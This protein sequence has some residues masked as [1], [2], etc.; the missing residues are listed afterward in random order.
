MLAFLR[1]TIIILG[2][3][4]SLLP[5]VLICLLRPF[6]PNLVY[7]ASRPYFW[8]SRL[9]GLSVEYRGAELL[10]A[11]D[12]AVY[13]SN[14]QNTFDLFVCAGAVRPNTVTIGKRSLL[15]IPVFG[16]LYWITGNILID[17]GNRSK[18]ANTI[19]EAARKVRERNI[20]VWMFPEGTRSNKRGMLNFKTGAFRLA[21]KAHEP[22]VP[23]VVSCLVDKVRLNRWSNGKVIIQYLP[24][25]TVDK[26]SDIQ[27]VTKQV[28]ADML[29][30]YER[31]SAETDSGN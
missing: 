15:Y 20:S 22:I 5:T 24:P 14:H 18:A 21:L 9:L 17:R 28:R 31:I 1:L 26:Q 30:V 2:L 29:A 19:D 7:L 11:V 27:S 8:V 16:L 10:N 23:V 4:V 13:V 12:K 6:H 25:L 3:I